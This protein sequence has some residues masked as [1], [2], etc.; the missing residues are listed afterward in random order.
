MSV[1]REANPGEGRKRLVWIVSGRICRK[2]VNGMDKKP[3]RTRVGY[4]VK[5]I[6]ENDKACQVEWVT[7]S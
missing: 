1:K 3:I 2:G 6:D 4:G 5:W 7:V